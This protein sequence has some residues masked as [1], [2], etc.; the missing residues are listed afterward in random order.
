MQKIPEDM[1][2]DVAAMMSRLMSR[3]TITPLFK[4]DVT[5]QQAYDLILAAY[6]AE[7]NARHGKIMLDRPTS[8]HIR[9]A[10]KALTTS[11]KF[12]MAFCGEVGNGKTTLMS[13]ICNLAG[14]LF[15]KEGLFFRKV[16]A[17]EVPGIYENRRDFRALCEQPFLAVDDLGCE[18]VEVLSYGNIL[19]PTVELL[20]TR[21]EMRLYTMVTTN[22]EPGK[23]KERYGERIADRLREMMCIIPFTNKTYRT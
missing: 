22:I 23:I 6:T 3:K 18:P 8:S 10:A 13:A 16:N 5:E 2:I 11:G 17:T 1:K 15:D 12:G 14:Y 20:M 19:T 21:Y 7:V 9:L 4:L